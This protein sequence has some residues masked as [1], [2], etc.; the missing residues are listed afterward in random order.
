MIH[1]DYK[2]YVSMLVMLNS[3]YSELVTRAKQEAEWYASQWQQAQT[4]TSSLHLSTIKSI[5]HSSPLNRQ[6]INAKQAE[7]NQIAN[8]HIQYQQQIARLEVEFQK[9][10]EKYNKLTSQFGIVI[11]VWVVGAIILGSMAQ[12]ILAGIIGV[13][14]VVLILYVLYES[15]KK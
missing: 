4:T 5:D 10:E 7:L 1:Q 15:N 2:D 8:T 13:P 6:N 12:D 14:I 9:E 3:Q 11:A